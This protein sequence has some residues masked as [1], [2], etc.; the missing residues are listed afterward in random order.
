MKPK[1]NLKIKKLE[2][3]K[4]ENMQQIAFTKGDFYKLLKISI[5]Y[6]SKSINLTWK[7]K[8]SN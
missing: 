3:L 8:N 5:N 1:K 7:I 6:Q 4:E 2:K